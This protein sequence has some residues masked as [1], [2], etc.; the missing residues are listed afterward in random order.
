MG[1]GILGT[2]LDLWQRVRPSD[3]GEPIA[4]PSEDDFEDK[5][6]DA[7]LEDNQ[8]DHFF[9]KY[10]IWG[11]RDD[12]EVNRCIE[13]RAK[14]WKSAEKVESTSDS[15]DNLFFHLDDGLEAL[16][17]GFVWLARK[18]QQLWNSIPSEQQ[19]MLKF[20]GLFLMARAG[21]WGTSSENE[22]HSN[23]KDDSLRGSFK[24]RGKEYEVVAYADGRLSIN[25]QV[26]KVQGTKTE[27]EIASIN[28]DKM[29]YNP[30]S[31]TLSVKIKGTIALVSKYFERQVGGDK[32]AELLEVLTT[33]NE[34]IE[35][36][37]MKATGIR[38]V[39]SD[40]A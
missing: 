33:S 30:G 1:D 28:I 13:R 20:A 35:T 2:F 12:E 7:V 29:E 38:L 34:A 23:K 5:R 27:T 19:N 26:W 31:E 9:D 37:E 24:F 10:G 18:P 36:P 21:L 40:K 6:C 25:G 15:E 3:D 8:Y 16:G 11:R 32:L 22:F 39:P 17:R 4:K 14:R